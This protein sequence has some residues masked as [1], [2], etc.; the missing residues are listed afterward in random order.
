MVTVLNK[1]F[2]S[3][4]DTATAILLSLICNF[5][6]QFMIFISINNS[7]KWSH[8]IIIS[9]R[10]SLPGKYILSVSNTF[11]FKLHCPYQT[12]LTIAVFT[13]SCMV[14]DFP[15]KTCMCGWIHQVEKH[16]THCRCL[17]TFRWEVVCIVCVVWW[18]PGVM[19]TEISVSLSKVKC[20]ILNAVLVPFP[21]AA[22]GLLS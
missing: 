22:L 4:I 14:F 11:L 10:R 1:I 15:C 16:F 2:T 20:S 18:M 9:S 5:P 6:K 21:K 12:K 8:D 7:F 13:F 3:H 19:L 17:Y